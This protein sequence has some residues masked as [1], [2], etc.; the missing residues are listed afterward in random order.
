MSALITG[1]LLLGLI[2]LVIWVARLPVHPP[3]DP[4]QPFDIHLN[5]WLEVAD[6]DG[7]TPNTRPSRTRN[8]AKRI[9]DPTVRDQVLLRL[10]PTR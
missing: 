1:C 6:I 8:W 7:I 9:P 2:L 10:L 3:P 5:Y 4:E